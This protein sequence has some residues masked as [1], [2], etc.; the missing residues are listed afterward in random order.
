MDPR[1]AAYRRKLAVFVLLLLGSSC[2]WL[3]PPERAYQ[4]TWTLYVSG[5]YPKAIE[6]VSHQVDRWK[7]RPTSYWYWK[8]H[9][10]HIETLLAQDK[11]PEALLLL[12]TAIPQTRELR[13]LAYRYQIDLADAILVS[14]P[15]R[16]AALLDAAAAGTADS[17][18]QIRIRQLRGKAALLVRN[19]GL[20]AA[21]FGEALRLA[22]ST[23]NLYR[24]A[25]C[26]NNLS[27]CRRQLER[28]EEAVAL[29]SQAVD[30]A[31]RAHASGVQAQAHNN[32]AIYDLYL[33]DLDGARDHVQQAIAILESIDKRGDVAVALNLMGLLRGA[34]DDNAG[35][36][37]S[38][39]R[40]YRIAMELGQK[41]EAARYAANLSLALIKT[42]RWKDAAAWNQKAAQLVNPKDINLVPFLI[43][44]QARIAEG[45]GD[46]EDA[47]AACRNLLASSQ[48]NR[49]LRWEA[50]AIEAG[51][52]AKARRFPQANGEFASALS[53]INA[54][55]SPLENP[56]NR[57]TLLSRLIPFYK[58]YVDS[59]VEQNDDAKALTVIESSRARV[60]SE[61]LRRS[62][63]PMVFDSAALRRL[64][65]STRSSIV[66]FWL[67]PGRSFAWLI[68]PEAVRR[69]AL[70]G[71]GEI[72]SLVSQYR[73]S[74]EHSWG[75]P[76]A[77]HDPAAAKLWAALLADIAPLIPH[78]GRVIVVPDGVLHRLNLET[79]PVP[80]PSP[81]YWAE[82]VEVAIAPSMTLL[83]S[84][85][86]P[87][88]PARASLLLMGAPLPAPQFDK[89]PQAEAEITAIQN[90]LPDASKAVFTGDNATL[91]SYWQVAPGHFSLIHF[92]AHA[93][94]N[95]ESPLES[96]IILSP[97]QGQYRLKARDII[98]SELT[99]EL[100]TISACRSAGARVY[101]GEGLIGLAWAFLE[102]GSG[103]VIA[104]LWDV[105][106]G[107]SRILMDQLY[108][109]IAAGQPPAEA[110]HHAKLAMLQG[111]ARYRKPYFWGPFQTYI[112]VAR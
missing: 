9:L 41:N 56:Q 58:L 79:L 37:A 95:P 49:T 70:P 82:D 80:G 40:A 3:E 92:A 63:E 101:A 29:A 105:N 47:A 48:K 85:P 24:E 64:A 43:R 62:A 39:E 46:A 44:N 28:Y 6:T 97:D 73:N 53:E 110:L 23:G 33:G 94:P 61:S 8:F 60:L 69:F 16:A 106:D 30:K 83:A 22:T 111:D 84:A 68:T 19:P 103:A 5:S 34:Q 91:A 52:D 72:E 78:G 27:L 107:S 21:Q 90:R 112:R 32:L 100:V 99:A 51:M 76:L 75:D 50:Y 108:A 93:E 89:L 17:D 26:L 57:I 54:G 35:A 38:H 104:G 42:A 66:S 4:R 1:T 81:H 71:S 12:K 13:Q 96:A 65:T 59:L 45:R 15:P 7:D 88:P 98:G 14:D 86:Q 2:A 102:A 36:S 11:A 10:L 109:G 31:A 67:A 55:L 77:G 87:R 74:V 25:G 18:L 20:A